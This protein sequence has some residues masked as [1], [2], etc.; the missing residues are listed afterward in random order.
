MDETRGRSW[1]ERLEERRGRGTRVTE[2]PFRLDP[3]LVGAPLAGLSRRAG[4]WIVDAALWLL[5][6]IPL[7]ILAGFGAL[8]L[9]APDAARGVVAVSTRNLTETRGETMYVALLELVEHRRPGLL[10]SSVG[11]RLREGDRVGA[12]A[13]VDSLGLDFSLDLSGSEPSSYD[14]GTRTV[15][16]RNDVLFGRFSSF[17]GIFSFGILYHTLLGALGRGR[18]PGK[19]LFGCRARRLDGGGFSLWTSFNRAGGYAAS[20]STLGLGFVQALADPNR[21]ALHD[22]M[23]GTVVVRAPRWGRSKKT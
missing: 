17:V 21:Q 11:E 5:F 23:N 19:W 20:F 6:G 22:K 1:R 8:W 14:A 18:T 15:N 10:P 12:V 7:L 2:E 9:Q 3:E 4:A 13:M 16:I